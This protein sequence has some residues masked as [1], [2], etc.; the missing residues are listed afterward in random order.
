MLLEDT[1][2]FFNI[3]NIFLADFF[4]SFGD[5]FNSLQDWGL[6]KLFITLVILALFLYGTMR[7]L[8]IIKDKTEFENAEKIGTDIAL[9][10]ATARAAREIYDKTK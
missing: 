2:G 6:L 9:E 10:R 8:K 5:V 1:A 7:V 3:N 4:F